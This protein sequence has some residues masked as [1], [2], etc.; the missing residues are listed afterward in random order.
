MHQ[1]LEAQR[2]RAWLAED[3]ESEAMLE[4]V[5]REEAR[6]ATVVVAALVEEAE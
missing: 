3:T 2:E 1:T 6:R 5:I 4:A